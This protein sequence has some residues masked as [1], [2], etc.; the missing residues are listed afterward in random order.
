MYIS[1]ER[2]LH[3]RRQDKAHF[4]L[5]VSPGDWIAPAKPFFRVHLEGLLLKSFLP[6]QYPPTDSPSSTPPSLK[7]EGIKP[8]TSQGGG[9]IS[10]H[11]SS[12]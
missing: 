3:Q 6:L 12:P 10:S 4:Y 7:A 9:T 5:F 1:N 11:F 8:S 2:R